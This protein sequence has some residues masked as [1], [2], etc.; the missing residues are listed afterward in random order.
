MKT[1]RWGTLFLCQHVRIAEWS[2]TNGLAKD[3]R[4]TAKLIVV[5]PVLREPAAH[6]SLSEIRASPVAANG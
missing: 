2:R 4:T 5:R 3:T 1:I 6:V